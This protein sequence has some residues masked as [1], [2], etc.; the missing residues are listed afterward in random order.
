MHQFRFISGIGVYSDV[1]E[2]VVCLITMENLFLGRTMVANVAWV[3][4][5]SYGSPTRLSHWPACRPTS[6]LRFA[7]L[8][9]YCMN[10]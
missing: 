5:F 7:C 8:E 3:G 2:V 9:D 10:S 1:V 6:G 4:P